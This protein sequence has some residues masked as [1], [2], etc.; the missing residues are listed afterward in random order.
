MEKR[1]K[2]DV[3]FRKTCFI[4]VSREIICENGHFFYQIKKKR[5]DP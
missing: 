2:D 4:W 3:N 1:N 5:L